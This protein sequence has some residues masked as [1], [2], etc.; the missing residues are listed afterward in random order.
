ML[1][2]RDANA[3]E[4][5]VDRAFFAGLVG[6]DAFEIP[7]GAPG[8]DVEAEVS[9]SW[10]LLQALL[11]QSE[12]ARQY[13][14]RLLLKRAAERPAEFR[15]AC[16]GK[17]LASL[18]ELYPPGEREA[19]ADAIGFGAST[20]G[21]AAS[22]GGGGRAEAAVT[23]SLDGIARRASG[24][25]TPPRSAITPTWGGQL[26]ES[27]QMPQ[28]QLART[29]R[30]PVSISDSAATE[31][32]Q[33]SMVPV[34]DSASTLRL[35]G[36]A[37]EASV[38]AWL[39]TS[40][41]TA[42]GVSEA[43]HKNF[44][45]VLSPR[46]P[47]LSANLEKPVFQVPGLT[48]DF[49]AS[50]SSNCNTGRSC[51][52][53]RSDAVPAAAAL[54]VPAAAAL[55][56]GPA[57]DH[58]SAY[59]QGLLGAR[60]A[61]G[62]S[63]AADRDEETGS[64]DNAALVDAGAER[65]RRT[66]S[67]LHAVP[68]LPRKNGGGGA[69]RA[70]VAA[71]LA[72][73]AER[74]RRLALLSQRTAV[75][76]ILGDLRLLVDASQAGDQQVL[77]WQA[78]AARARHHL[79]MSLQSCLSIA[80]SQ[81]EVWRARDCKLKFVSSAAALQR[82][83][84]FV[85]ALA[86]A[87]QH[88]RRT[89]RQRL[90]LQH[91]AY[92]LARFSKRQVIQ[93]WRTH[94]Y[95]LRS[96][97]AAVQ[98]GI[99][100]LQGLFWRAWSVHKVRELSQLSDA[101]F[102]CSWKTKE[103]AVHHTGAAASLAV[104]LQQLVRDR[105]RRALRVH[106]AAC[107]HANTHLREGSFLLF[108]TVERCY[109]RQLAG[110]LSRWHGVLLRSLVNSEATRL[111]QAARC[112]AISRLRRALYCWRDCVQRSAALHHS[113]SQAVVR[114]QRWS[115]NHLREHVA[116]SRCKQSLE[117]VCMARIE[118]V[119]C[120][121][122]IGLEA[123]R[124]DSTIRLQAAAD[125]EALLLRKFT[126]V[127]HRALGIISRLVYDHLIRQYWKCWFR[128]FKCTPAV[129]KLGAIIR[130]ASCR[131]G[132]RHWQRQASQKALS[133]LEVQI[134]CFNEFATKRHRLSCRMVDKCG[135][136]AIEAE[137]FAWQS[138]VKVVMSSW[139]A[140]VA[141]RK[142]QLATQRHACRL[143]AAVLLG[144]FRIRSLQPWR[145]A[146]ADEHEF[147]KLRDHRSQ[148][149]EL[150]REH[151]EE[152]DK[153]RFEL[154]ESHNELR[155]ARL[156]AD[157][158]CD[159]L[160]REFQSQEMRCFALEAEVEAS[161]ALFT[162]QF[163]AQLWKAYCASVVKSL[164]NGLVLG[165]MQAREQVVQAREQVMQAKSAVALWQRIASMGTASLLPRLR[166]AMSL[167]AV[168]IER[169]RGFS[170]RT[171]A[172]DEALRVRLAGVLHKAHTKQRL[173][174]FRF[175]G[176]TSNAV[177]NT[178]RRLRRLACIMTSAS[179]RG[180]FKDL[181]RW[182]HKSRVLADSTERFRSAVFADRIAGARL[183]ILSLNAMGRARK[184]LALAYLKAAVDQHCVAIAA[185]RK[186]Q[187]VA[188]PMLRA[189]Q[190]LVPRRIAWA[191]GQ[192]R[193]AGHKAAWFQ[194]AALQHERGLE[195]RHALYAAAQFGQVRHQLTRRILQ[196]WKAL[197]LGPRRLFFAVSRATSS[198][199]Q[200]SLQRLTL[201]AA[202]RGHTI[203]KASF[204]T[205]VHRRRRVAILIAVMRAWS[206]VYCRRQR[207]QSWRLHGMQ[208]R[209]AL[210]LQRTSFSAFV[211]MRN[212]VQ[213]LLRLSGILRRALG[214]SGISMWR[215][216][217]AKVTAVMAAS[218]LRSLKRG[219]MQQ[220]A[221]L[222]R[223][224]EQRTQESA[225]HTS[226][227][228]LHAW[229]CS[230]A[231]QASS[232]AAVKKHRRLVAQVLVGRISSLMR[233]RLRSGLSRWRCGAQALSHRHAADTA[234]HQRVKIE[235][236]DRVRQ[237][238]V[239]LGSLL[240]RRTLKLLSH[241]F[242]GPWR[243]AQWEAL[244]RSIDSSST[245]EHRRLRA[246]ADVL[247]S[248]LDATRLET[249]K[250]DSDLR[251]KIS[252]LE[253]QLLAESIRNNEAF[254][255]ADIIRE[256]IERERQLAERERQEHQ[257]AQREFQEHLQC[258]ETRHCAAE[259]HAET[260]HCAAEARAEAAEE[261]AK[262][263]VRG[264]ELQTGMEI[265]ELERRLR[266]GQAK[267][268]LSEGQRR[269]AMNEL[270]SARTEIQAEIRSA[271]EKERQHERLDAEKERVM[272][273]HQLALRQHAGA[274]DKRAREAERRAES[275]ACRA[276]Q[277]VEERARQTEHKMELALSDKEKSL[278]EHGRAVQMQAAMAEEQERNMRRLEGLLKEQSDQTRRERKDHSR[279]LE[280]L[281]SYA[282]VSE[283]KSYLLEEQVLA[284]KHQLQRDHSELKASERAWASDR[285]AMLTA[286]TAVKPIPRTL[287][288]GRRGRCCSVPS[289]NG[290]ASRSPA[291]G[292][293]HSLGP[294]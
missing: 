55:V 21:A 175:L 126:L 280:Q 11:V 205:S 162:A 188:F 202:R 26:S 75:R 196:A 77:K 246:V 177:A 195:N 235:K 201:H 94:H 101:F 54:A 271:V 209:M 153:F 85:R 208:R 100:R 138:L 210:R 5:L 67:L 34:S 59:L 129:H 285:A 134:D 254:G 152:V 244:L 262:S 136:S 135:I 265:A 45:Q 289:R 273:E 4:R 167:A 211:A 170:D 287:S 31:R 122:D 112:G 229:R 182:S 48:L 267:H 23:D 78:L 257:D 30:L 160:G 253:A 118:S 186:F 35:P 277:L 106:R 151:R 90:L 190:R 284:L 173:E 27:P 230:S 28:G 53:G 238:A 87:G 218:D 44:D 146:V 197:A 213:A 137:A 272:G 274:L 127:Q 2:R 41:S 221:D 248:E 108:H 142:L 198:R 128:M 249:S 96:N 193:H 3:F 61:V 159:G 217:T 228:L 150:R 243:Y 117:R 247:R 224:I 275:Q 7:P 49:G 223:I 215:S 270:E 250:L 258:R 181:H 62:R 15:D 121:R 86:L 110:A 290:N 24:Y 133:Y 191:L 58:D 179:F 163:T 79:L 178:R 172:R 216:R 166:A 241:C 36:A 200:W 255:E 72:A 50:G 104:V 115:W 145:V 66:S 276:E 259:A 189:L 157:V 268:V 38:D 147:E 158:Q 278:D 63:G 52:T 155:A 71:E 42:L 46:R 29:G 164:K 171:V 264:L 92:V 140:E 98:L 130:M 70:R 261:L 93:R 1:G 17:R 144:A 80:A 6:P 256:V 8:S 73:V 263:K 139:R 13:A 183:L 18:L 288:H 226:R 105:Q 281:R 95:G 149:T 154:E 9:R 83:N 116:R 119:R 14:R 19:L 89:V 97:A 114:V 156:R 206:A 165:M 33:L 141:E 60:A 69:I 291:R 240:Q 12:Q 220:R 161:N 132:F 199:V 39:K 231:V 40:S 81:V 234:I 76:H 225:E 37:L 107:D 16:D 176:E 20:P 84:E 269:A 103:R 68:P 194:R 251:S 292:T 56:L 237:G 214:A 125:R 25:S 99:C 245:R 204:F 74:W 102:Q 260:R 57:Q 148:I 64:T 187:P 286:V 174:F 239:L 113:L 109:R 242:H 203:V 91:L 111:R 51:L 222:Q 232:V 10:I 22:G 184:R 47:V 233:D 169:K 252:H 120:E 227:A 293:R 168:E 207:V 43:A 123:E 65:K 212:R 192:W 279:G 282:S 32:G 143:L 88:H 124:L 219:C 131:L 180:C 82:K 283:S 294:I 266:D 236:L 185:T